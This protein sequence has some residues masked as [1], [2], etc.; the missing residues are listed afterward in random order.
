M[1]ERDREREREGVFV[2]VKRGLRMWSVLIFLIEVHTSEEDCNLMCRLL[3]TRISRCFHT[4]DNQEQMTRNLRSTAA[5]L[6]GDTAHEDFTKNDR[7]TQ[8]SGVQY[9]LSLTL[10]SPVSSN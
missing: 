8:T 5:S 10:L 6:T 2:C 1:R 4:K 7:I 9:I 3:Q